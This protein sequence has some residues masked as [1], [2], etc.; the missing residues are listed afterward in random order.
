MGMGSGQGGGRGTTEQSQEAS[1][2]SHHA[3]VRMMGVVGSK[4]LSGGIPAKIEEGT[5][6][7]T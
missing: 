7:S 2:E 5:E 4:A 3:K 1:M 6:P